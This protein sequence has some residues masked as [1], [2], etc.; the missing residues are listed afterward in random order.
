MDINEINKN[1]IEN[2]IKATDNESIA[3]ATDSNVKTIEENG[4]FIDNAVS[5][6]DTA[7]SE[8][9]EAVDAATDSDDDFDYAVV[10][11]TAADT[12]LIDSVLLEDIDNENVYV[13]P[14]SK[15]VPDMEADAGEV[16]NADPEVEA[17]ISETVGESKNEEEVT[18]SSD[19]TEKIKPA[20]GETCEAD[21]E[22][23]K[24]TSGEN[25]Q[26]EDEQ[27]SITDFVKKYGYLPYD[28]DEL[29]TEKIYDDDESDGKKKKKRRRSDLNSDQRMMTIFMVIG[30]ILLLILLLKKFA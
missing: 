3:E 19:K 1:S 27:L 16:I 11:S 4:S 2:E 17:T 13:E 26:A 8:I 18:E 20:D 10:E 15:D 5:D 23:D 6:A 24:G 22:S 14:E 21:S 28:Q 30:V 7:S 12:S 25:P 29:K 9:N